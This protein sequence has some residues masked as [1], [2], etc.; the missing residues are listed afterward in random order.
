M[1]V[2]PEVILDEF[3]SGAEV[4]KIYLACRTSHSGAGGSELLDLARNVPL[5]KKQ[6][7]IVRVMDSGH[8][9][10]AEHMSFTFLIKDIS[11]ACSHQAVRHRPTSPTQTSQRY[12]ESKDPRFVVPP[13]IKMN[14]EAFELFLDTMALVFNAYRRFIE[15][16]IPAEDARYVFTNA[17]ATNIEVTMNLREFIHVCNERLCGKAQWEIRGVVR[18]M[19]RAVEKRVPFLGRYLVPK[20]EVLRRCPEAHT[21]GRYA[22][23]H[24]HLLKEA[25]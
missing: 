23:E 20:C 14:A 10:V 5:R 12:V 16:G 8:M 9:S 17:T 15:L 22:V 4:N 7:L 24:H 19:A 3:N 18:M 11:R 1:E 21:C 6:D 2:T 13:S 25:E